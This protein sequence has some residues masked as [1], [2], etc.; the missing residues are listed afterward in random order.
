[1]LP[2]NHE[3][4]VWRALYASDMAKRIEDFRGR[5]DTAFLE[6]LGAPG[7]DLSARPAGSTARRESTKSSISRQAT[8]EST[9]RVVMM[10]QRKIGG[11]ARSAL[12]VDELMAFVTQVMPLKMLSERVRRA[13][14]EQASSRSYEPGQVIC[15][16]GEEADTFFVILSGSVQVG[17]DARLLCRCVGSGMRARAAAVAPR[18]RVAR[19]AS[20]RDWRV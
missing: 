5:E 15:R 2:A 9:D 16:R 1:M 17:S 7:P 3:Y 6:A 18:H 14:C 11:K 13:L 19:S 20:P 10:L 12:E 4:L 8:S